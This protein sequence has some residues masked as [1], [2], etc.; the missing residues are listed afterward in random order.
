MHHENGYINGH[1]DD[2]KPYCESCHK[3]VHIQARKECRCKYTPDELNRLSSNSTKRRNRDMLTKRK[4][5]Y[6]ETLMPFVRLSENVRICLST[7]KI[8]V[9]SYFIAGH[10]KQIKYIEDSWQPLK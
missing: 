5:L 3:K 7:G 6:T 2:V 10:G 4:N 9:E 8:S 1:E